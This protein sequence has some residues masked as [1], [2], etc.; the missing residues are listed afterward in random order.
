MDI[1]VQEGLET[2]TITRLASSLDA[3]VGSLY[4]YFEGKEALIVALQE[5]AICGFRDQLMARLALAD[6]RA[7]DDMVA[8]VGTLYRLWVALTAYLEHAHSSPAHHRLIDT[9]M[10]APEAVLDDAAARAVDDVVQAVLAIYGQL[11]QAAAQSGSLRPIE[12]QELEVRTHLLW[13]AVHGLDH[14]RKRERIQAPHLH[15]EAL[16]DHMMRSLLTG[17]GAPEPLIDAAYALAAPIV[18]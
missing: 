15:V 3:S 17:W 10:S 13:A 11:L 16:T 9:M 7:P 1:V 2:L 5:Q 14:F 4:R 8:G 18:E 12:P 6:E